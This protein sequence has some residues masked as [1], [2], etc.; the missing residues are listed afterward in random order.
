MSIKL[1]AL[2]YFWPR[3]SIF[4]YAGWQVEFHL[5]TLRN[6][7]YNN[8]GLW[9]PFRVIESSDWGNR[10]LNFIAGVRWQVT[11]FIPSHLVRKEIKHTHFHPVHRQSP[12]GWRATPI[13]YS[14]H[15]KILRAMAIKQSQIPPADLGFLK[16][17]QRHLFS[18]G[19]QIGELSKQFWMGYVCL[20]R[21]SCF[22][23]M[24][25]LGYQLF[26]PYSKLSLL[27]NALRKM[28]EAWP[29]AAES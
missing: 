8:D 13:V 11:A 28:T 12:P 25:L 2:S 9:R 27:T 23:Q 20:W 24:S 26:L 1:Q 18:G 21:P 17:Q 4:P 6:M 15:R 10:L 19:L 7:S 3:V 16:R 14:I 22:L 5:S 29:L